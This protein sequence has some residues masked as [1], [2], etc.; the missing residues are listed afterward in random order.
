MFSSTISMSVQ[1]CMAEVPGQGSLHGLG[2]KDVLSQEPPGAAT[3]EVFQPVQ[4]PVHLHVGTLQS[5]A[6]KEMVI[7]QQP[8]SCHK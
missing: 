3:K 1:P 4:C 7:Q 5:Q 6:T 8:E 2:T